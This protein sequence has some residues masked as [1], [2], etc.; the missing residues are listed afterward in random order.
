[1]RVLVVGAGGLLGSHLCANYPDHTI[2]IFRKDCDILDS[3][4]I[5]T[6]FKKH[7]F[8]VVVNCAGVVPKNTQ[9]RLETNS[10]GVHNLKKVC[11][12]RG[13]KLVHIS[14]DCVFSGKRGNY[15]ESDVP[16]TDTAYGK[17]KL[18]GEFDPEEFHLIIRT[19]F[20]GMPDPTGRGLLSWLIDQNSAPGHINSLWNGCTVTHLANWIMHHIQFDTTGLI[21]LSTEKLS[22]YQVLKTVKDVFEWNYTVLYGTQEPISDKSLQTTRT[23]L[24][25]IYFKKKLFVDQVEEMRGREWRWRKWWGENGR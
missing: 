24:H 8:D 23:D 3:Q 1:M 10:V 19:S 6:L 18:A 4:S 17:S 15:F 14:T 2:P 12:N 25:E 21:H 9:D 13:V 22:K 16:D 11:D 20:V 7:T 5:Q